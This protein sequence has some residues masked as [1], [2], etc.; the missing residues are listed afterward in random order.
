MVYKLE[1]VAFIFSAT[2]ILVLC[3]P[4][5]YSLLNIKI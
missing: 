4:F 3:N 1:V 5:K 2:N